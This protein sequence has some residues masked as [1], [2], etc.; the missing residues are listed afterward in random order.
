MGMHQNAEALDASQTENLDP[1]EEGRIGE[2][3]AGFRSNQGTDQARV[4]QLS[5]KQIRGP[6]GNGPIIWTDTQS[7]ENIGNDQKR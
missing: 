6:G 5:H 1:N 4:S 2:V 7:E 3:I